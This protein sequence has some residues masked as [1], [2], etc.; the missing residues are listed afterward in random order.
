MNEIG[1]TLK[2]ARE[3]SGVSIDEASKDLN[4][5][6]LTI[7][8]IESGNI[9]CFKDIFALKENIAAYAKYLGLDSTKMVDLFNE[10]LFE[11]TS[12]IS[13]SDIET[14]IKE[15]Q[16][17]QEHDEETKISSPYTMTNEVYKSKSLLWVYVLVAILVALVTFWAV[18]QITIDNNRSSMSSII[19]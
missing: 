19:R 4:I 17:E 15:Q 18:K 8:N 11:Y 2:Q 16:K 7:E 6:P 14:K 5:K 13:I 1:L 9:G 10:Y 12:K 3:N